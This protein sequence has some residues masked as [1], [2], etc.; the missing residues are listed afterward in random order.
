L[1]FNRRLRAS[2]RG[3]PFKCKTD[4]IALG[5]IYFFQGKPGNVH[6]IGRRLIKCNSFA[7]SPNLVQQ[8]GLYSPSL[9]ISRSVTAGLK[10]QHF[11]PNI[12]QPVGDDENHVQTP[13]FPPFGLPLSSKKQTDKVE[14]GH[15]GP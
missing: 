3:L 5:G 6:R 13:L 11:P 14:T 7:E 15:L 2:V 8:T 12:P 10:L 1:R 9:L 4:T